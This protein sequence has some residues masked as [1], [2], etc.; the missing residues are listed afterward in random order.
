METLSRNKDEA[1]V[2]GVC[3]GL[4]EYF[5]TDPTLVR[6]SFVILTFFGG[7]GIIAYLILIIIMPINNTPNN[8]E[9]PAGEGRVP[10]RASDLKKETQALFKDIDKHISKSHNSSHGIFGFTILL[11][12]L[13]LLTNNFFPD[14]D[15]IKLWPLLLVLLGIGIM[16]KHHEHK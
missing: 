13:L 6:I 9:G 1:I 15:L 16:F 10:D 7:F 3:A 11:I 14:Y 5:H 2:A 8:P 12:G 4:A